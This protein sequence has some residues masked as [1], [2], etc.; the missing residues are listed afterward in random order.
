MRR[1]IVWMLGLALLSAGC[2]VDVGADE[3]KQLKERTTEAGTAA[4]KPTP[5]AEATPADE[6]TPADERPATT[7]DDVTGTTWTLTYYDATTAVE[8]VHDVTFLAGGE[9]FDEHPNNTTTDNDR[10][11]QFGAT[12][13]L[14]FNDSYAT[15]TGEIS[16]PGSL[17]GTA[18]NVTGSSWPWSAIL[19]D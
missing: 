8:Y 16:A 15:Y 17:S 3:P 2:T 5:A 18:T 11:E 1:S 12:V 4:E 10:W 6:P 13:I 9:M 7:A 19:K 14:Y